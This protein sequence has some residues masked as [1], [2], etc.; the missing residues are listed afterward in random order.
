MKDIQLRLFIDFP[1]IVLHEGNRICFLF[2]HMKK[3]VKQVPKENVGSLKREKS[4]II[5]D[6]PS[7]LIYLSVEKEKLCNKI[8]RFF[9]SK[10]LKGA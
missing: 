10:S 9:I 3:G 5:Y 6:F 8:K 1:R 2:M 4:F 7:I